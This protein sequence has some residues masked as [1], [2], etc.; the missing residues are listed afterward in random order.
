MTRS[1]A[2]LSAAKWQELKEV[3][4]F[5]ETFAAQGLPAIGDTQTQARLAQTLEAL[6]R[7]GLEDFYRGDVAR[8][9]ARD[10]EKL[11]SPLRL[12][13]LVGAVDFRGHAGVPAATGAE[14]F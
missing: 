3:P 2:L 12:H 7:N 14:G 8:S 5:A 1:Q 10:L 6:S 9:L 13:V 11:G 4:G